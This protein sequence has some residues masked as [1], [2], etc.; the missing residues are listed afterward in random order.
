MSDSA[1][2]ELGVIPRKGRGNNLKKWKDLCYG[3]SYLPGDWRGEEELVFDNVCVAYERCSVSRFWVREFYRAG[4]DV[5]SSSGIYHGVGEAY[6]LKC[7]GHEVSDS[8]FF[9]C[10]RM[11]VLVARE[12]FGGRWRACEEFVVKDSLAAYFYARLVVGGRLPDELHGVLGLR[13]FEGVDYALRRYFVDFAQ[14]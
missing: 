10:P 9:G 6:V 7:L 14:I 5:L 1:D 11:C 12:F 2:C 4:G 3:L 13:S 8:V